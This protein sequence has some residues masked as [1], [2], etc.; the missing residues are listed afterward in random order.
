M[1]PLGGRLRTESE[2][3]DSEHPMIVG[4]E[5]NFSMIL[6]RCAQNLEREVLQRK[7]NFGFVREQVINIL[8]RELHSN[9]R[10][11]E[12]RMQSFP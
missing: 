10:I 11:F 1:Y 5:R 12:I 9:V 8:A 6:R 7:Q 3:F 4:I 2:F